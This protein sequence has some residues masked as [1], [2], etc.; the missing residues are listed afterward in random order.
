MC[1]SLEHWNQLW[2]NFQTYIFII[3][4]SKRDR[5]LAAWNDD[6]RRSAAASQK[7]LRA[8]QLLHERGGLVFVVGDF[9]N[10]DS[11]QRKR[12]RH[13]P[14]RRRYDSTKNGSSVGHIDVDCCFVGECCHRTSSTPFSFG[15]TNPIV[16]AGSAQWFTAPATTA[17]R[18]STTAW[19]CSETADGKRHEFEQLTTA[20]GR[21]SSL[22]SN[23]KSVGIGN[24][25]PPHSTNCASNCDGQQWYSTSTTA[26]S[27]EQRNSTTNSSDE[28]LYSTATTHYCKQLA[29]CW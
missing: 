6:R 4:A 25:R 8:E 24:L 3:L 9:G 11:H 19:G 22:T 1:F 15:D 18:R 2:S 13:R 27:N 21:A 28:Q 16:T 12:F 26:R 14:S 10:I 20:A 29:Y 23:P 7:R 5:Q 17:S